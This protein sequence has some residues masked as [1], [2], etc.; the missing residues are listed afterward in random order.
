MW[1][2][3]QRQ[4][5]PQSDVVWGVRTALWTSVAGEM[6]AG[7]VLLTGCL[8]SVKFFCEFSFG[9]TNDEYMLAFYDFK[10]ILIGYFFF[11]IRLFKETNHIF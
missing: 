5:Y 7:L 1:C 2:E 4:G 10:V 3:K 6:E 11:V 9:G 8:P